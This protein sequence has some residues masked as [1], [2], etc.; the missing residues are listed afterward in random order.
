M[1]KMRSPRTGCVSAAFC[2]ALASSLSQ[3][4]A[5]ITGVSSCTS[6]Q[7]LH[8]RLFFSSAEDDGSADERLATFLVPGR[9]RPKGGYKPKQTAKRQTKRQS[10]AMAL[11]AQ[12]RELLNHE[13]LTR[14]EELDL[15]RMVNQASKLRSSISQLVE[16]KK[17]ALQQEIIKQVYN[18][19]EGGITKEALLSSSFEDFYDFSFQSEDAL[20][21]PDGSPTLCGDEI[22]LENYSQ[23]QMELGI[24][25]SLD[26]MEILSEDDITSNLGLKGGRAELQRILL[27]GAFARDKLIRSNIRLV[28]YIAKRWARQSAKYDNQDGAK[29]VTIYAG[30]TSRPSLDEAIQEGILGLARAADRYDPSRGL[31]FSTYCTYWVTC[32]VRNC[33]QD[34]TTG[35]LRIPAQLHLVRVR[36]C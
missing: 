36:A 17:A 26:D 20:F 34:A 16:G 3:S 15:G 1:K 23:N 24:H 6:H 27:E 25:S 21:D 29:L 5:W 28:V 7:S 13:I 11:A 9:P 30:S 14:E 22:S 31:R 35:S 32:F 10:A 19:D 33:F 18:I 12:R 8:S 2:A 4:T